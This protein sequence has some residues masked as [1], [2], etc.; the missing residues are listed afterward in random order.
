MNL[1]NEV[2][3]KINENIEIFKNDTNNEEIKSDN[4]QLKIEVEILKNKI[5]IVQKEKDSNK[6]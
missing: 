6:I 4:D 2:C 3:V 1:I 5:N